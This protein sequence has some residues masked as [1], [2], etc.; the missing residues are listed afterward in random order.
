MSRAPSRT[1]RIRDLN[2]E[3]RQGGLGA[4]RGGRWLVTPGVIALGPAAVLAAARTVRKF[5]QFTPDN[6]PHEEHDFG[7]FDLAGEQLF[8]KID[9]YDL[10]ESDS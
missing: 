1:E 10:S 9:Y 8:W 7:A 3:F 5:D 2:D 4:G 6:D